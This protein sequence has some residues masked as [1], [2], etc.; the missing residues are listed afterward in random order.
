M[1]PH[2]KRHDG[3]RISSATQDTGERYISQ[4][5]G[6][7][8]GPSDMINPENAGLSTVMDV[9]TAVQQVSVGAMLN[10]PCVVT[11][12]IGTSL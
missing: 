6:L 8:N 3:S 11:E 4:L 9:Q 1:C 2:G 10:I 5:L 7:D 12:F